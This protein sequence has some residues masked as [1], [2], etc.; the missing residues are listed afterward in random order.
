M[1]DSVFEIIGYSIDYYVGPKLIGSI[2]MNEPDREVY[3]YGGKRTEILK[4]D[5]VLKNKKVLKK[6]TEVVTECIPLC[7]K[8]KV[9]FFGMQKIVRKK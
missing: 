8:S 7:G 9:S 2:I 4:Q 3:G 6:G 1:R 5:L